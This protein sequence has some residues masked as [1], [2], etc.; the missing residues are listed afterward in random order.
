MEGL[1]M[2]KDEP[3]TVEGKLFHFPTKIVALF[4]RNAFIMLNLFYNVKM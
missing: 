2:I 4:A 1:K 3:I